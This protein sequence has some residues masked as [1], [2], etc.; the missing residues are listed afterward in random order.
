MEFNTGSVNWM[1]QVSCGFL[2]CKMKTTTPPFAGLLQQ[3]KAF[4]H[5][6]NIY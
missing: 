6:T 4:I 5:S 1:R 2:T 3:L